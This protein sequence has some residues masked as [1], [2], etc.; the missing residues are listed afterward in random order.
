M[1]AVDRQ[2]YMHLVFCSLPNHVKSFHTLQPSILKPA[3]LWSGKQVISTLLYNIVPESKQKLNLISKAKIS[4]TVR[5]NNYYAKTFVWTL[6]LLLLC[7]CCVVV[8]VKEWCR[9]SST[10]KGRKKLFK[11]MKHKEDAMTESEVS[12]G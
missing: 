9:G 6:L 12:Q 5:K 8:F 3:M 7:L 1:L 4:V 2:D 10:S 11:K